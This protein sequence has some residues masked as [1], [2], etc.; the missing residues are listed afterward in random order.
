MCTNEEIKKQESIEIIT[1]LL[2][3]EPPDRVFEVFVF[4]QT[5][6]SQ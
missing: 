3:K 1:E 5:Y 4:I 6:L 2:L